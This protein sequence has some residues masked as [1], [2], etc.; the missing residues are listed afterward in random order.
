MNA[1]VVVFLPEYYFILDLYSIP[2]TGDCE[3]LGCRLG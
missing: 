2:G 3:I 1:L